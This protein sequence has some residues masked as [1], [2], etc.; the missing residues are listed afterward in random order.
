MLQR[1]QVL[2]ALLHFDTPTVIKLNGNIQKGVLHPPK[3]FCPFNFYFLLSAINALS[4][5]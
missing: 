1:V 2:Y 3:P 4:S 5:W